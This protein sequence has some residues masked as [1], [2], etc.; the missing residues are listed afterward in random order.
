M[1][2]SYKDRSVS[3]NKI[4][5]VYRNLNNNSFSIRCSKSKLV[6]AHGNDFIIKN[7]FSKVSESGRQRVIKEGRKNVHAYVEGEISE[8][9]VKDYE[10]LDEL[11]YNP[12][13]Q[14]NFTLK[15]N[16]CKFVSGDLYFKDGKCFVIN[17]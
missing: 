8:D 12:Y 4:V 10:I 14:A 3:P 5:Q 17:K 15:N 6:L 7:A 13:G 9:V 2:Q 16:K 1:I 11:Y